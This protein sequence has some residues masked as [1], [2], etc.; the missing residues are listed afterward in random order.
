MKIVTLTL[1]AIL[2]L[3]VNSSAAEL[4]GTVKSTAGKP[5]AEVFIYPNRSLNDIA[6]TDDN[7]FFSLPRHSRVIFFRRAGFRPLTKIVDESTTSLDVVL[8]EATATEWLIPSCSSTRD[9]EKRVG[10]SLRLSTTKEGT[11]HEGSDIDYSY[12]S[13]G[14]GPKENRVWLKGIGQG[15]YATLGVP[16]EEWVLHAKEFT[17][18]SYRSG[19]AEGADMRGRSVDGTYWRYIGRFGE[20]VEYSGLTEEQ[21]AFFDR[22][23]DKACMKQ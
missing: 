14:Y 20:S 12:F 3:A 9:S 8:E 1:V 17:E 21:A 16:P 11:V 7:G 19:K 13:I 15:S 5:L 23:I 2:Y 10:F 4:K 22:I 18:R 6:E